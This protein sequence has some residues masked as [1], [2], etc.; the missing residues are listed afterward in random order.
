[1]KKLRVNR[2]RAAAIAD[3]VKDTYSLDSCRVVT[4]QKQAMKR[5]VI[6][7]ND[8]VIGFIMTY[9][10][11]NG[12]D[13]NIFCPIAK[14]VAFDVTDHTQLILKTCGEALQYG[15]SRSMESEMSV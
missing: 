9:D 15:I 10:M 1:M 12:T 4:T 2:K 13:L 7:P 5:G 3:K 8:S 11:E 14:W 6:L